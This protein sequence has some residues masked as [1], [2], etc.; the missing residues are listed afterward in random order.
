MAGRDVAIIDLIGTFII[1]FI[2]FFYF[3]IQMLQIKQVGTPHTISSL[4]MFDN[5][6]L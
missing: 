6:L 3:I 4:A 2:I 1:K 5:V